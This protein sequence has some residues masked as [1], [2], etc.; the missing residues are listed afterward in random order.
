M[1]SVIIVYDESP[2]M[3]GMSAIILDGA[4]IGSECLV[5]AGALVILFRA[6]FIPALVRRSTEDR[7]GMKWFRGEDPREWLGYC[8]SPVPPVWLMLASLVLTILAVLC[9]I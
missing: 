6:V 3:I 2:L 1:C 5:A 4:E 8:R 9:A 7:D